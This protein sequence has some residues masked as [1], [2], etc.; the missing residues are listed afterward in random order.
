[1]G[2]PGTLRASFTLPAG[3]LWDVWVQGDIMPTVKLSVDGRTIASI[4]GQLSGNSLVPD[5]IP[6][7]PVRL[8]AGAHS[9]SLTRTSAG[10]GP[11]ELGSAVLDSIFLTPA[12]AGSS[13][14]LRSAP[15]TR[16]KTLCGHRYQW[17]EL[18]RA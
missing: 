8:A 2:H 11:G 18:T 3:G 16:W 14:T 4:S 5:T 10:L 13:P 7:T 12:R 15:A 17:V 1:M 9:L 6:A